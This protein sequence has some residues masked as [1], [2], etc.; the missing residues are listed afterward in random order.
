MAYT[1]EEVEWMR[2]AMGITDEPEQIKPVITPAVPA[3]SDAGEYLLL[4]NL[5]CIDADG[6]EFERHGKIYVPKN[7]EE[8]ADGSQI[9]KTPYNWIVY[10][11]SKGMCLPSFALSCNILDALWQSKGNPEYMQVLMQYKDKGNGYG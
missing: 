10:F 3:V 7:I 8:D 9:S 2:K 5:C 6:N 1:P 11:E 4:E